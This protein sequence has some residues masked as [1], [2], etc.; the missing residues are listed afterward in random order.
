MQVVKLLENNKTLC[1]EYCWRLWE[2]VG[3]L[4]YLKECK[5]GR[6][7]NWKTVRMVDDCKFSGFI[8]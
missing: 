7:Q 8:A 1:W 6:V 5:I 4:E 2:Y 3:V